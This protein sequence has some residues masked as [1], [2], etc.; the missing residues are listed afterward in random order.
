APMTRYR[1]V[2]LRF[3]T[4]R[5]MRSLTSTCCS[6]KGDGCVCPAAIAVSP[7][8]EVAPT[9]SRDPSYPRGASRRP[10]FASGARLQLQRHEL[11]LGLA[12][13]LERRRLG[14]PFAQP[15][16]QRA[17]RLARRH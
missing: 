8:A 4:P 1:R 6:L 14:P 13:L 16:A 10:P 3:R 17:D 7:P 11:L 5:S 9:C 2:R 12:G 15:V